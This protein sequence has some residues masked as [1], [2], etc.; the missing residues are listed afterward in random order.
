MQ[1]LL[2]VSWS[3]MHHNYNLICRRGM[4][5]RVCSPEYVSAS[6]RSSRHHNK[7]PCA[8]LFCLREMTRV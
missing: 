3:S 2:T 5:E 7:R 6:L 1:V 8:G 4:L